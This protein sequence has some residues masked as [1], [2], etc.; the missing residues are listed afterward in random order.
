MVVEVTGS[1]T[2]MKINQGSIQVITKAIIVVMLDY[3]GLWFSSEGA[4]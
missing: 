4:I 1:I 3:G 2:D